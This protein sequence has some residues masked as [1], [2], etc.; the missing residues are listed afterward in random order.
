M[1]DPFAVQGV[2]KS[3][4]LTPSPSKFSSN[5]SSK[6][7]ADDDDKEEMLLRVITC[8]KSSLSHYYLKLQLRD[9][10]RTILRQEATIDG[11]ET[12]YHA[13]NT[14]AGIAKFIDLKT[15]SDPVNGY[16]LD[17][18]CVFGVEVFVVENTYKEGC[19]SM[20]HKPATCYHTWKV[21]NF[22]TLVN[23]KYVSESF[24]CYKWNILFFPNGNL[25]GKGNSFSL[26]IGLSL[27][28]IA[29]GTKLLAKVIMRVKNQMNGK[30]IEHK[31]CNLYGP[32]NSSGLG[33]T[34]FIS[35]AKLKDPEQGFLVDDTL[36]IEAEVTLLGMVLAESRL[37]IYPTGNKRRNG[38]DHISI[39]LEPAET[40]S[41][42]AGWEV[43][44][45][46]N[47]FI[48]NH[49]Q[50][51]Y[52][53]I[54][55][56]WET[57]YHA[58]N[59]MSGIAKF[60]DLKTFSNPENGYLLDDT[61]VFG[62]EVFVVKNTFKEGCLS[63]MHEPATCYHTWK[64]TNFST[65]VNEKYDSESFGCNKWYIILYPNGNSDGK[66][67][68]ISLFLGLSLSS[69]APGTKLLVK[70]IMRV[71]NQMNGKHIVYQVS[72]MYPPRNSIALGWPR[73]MSLAK[74]KDPKLGF[75][76]ND[77]LIIEAEV[78]LLGMV[79]AKS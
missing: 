74:L 54:K 40:S 10:A 66:G 13:M 30:Y 5:S 27:S 70:Q 25:E 23:E 75:L 21:T 59:T 72:D 78:T 58:M 36:I 32:Q 38:K 15:F 19:L 77:S 73:F 3:S 68:S 9:S 2:T 64:V 35:L 51:K 22:S 16:L 24:G 50:N 28:S 79:L 43:N 7:P 12:R 44:V 17:D 8:S 1:L 60:I 29:P 42:P 18:I 56:G 69:I 14:I 61:C 76:V 65:L 49:L 39:Y 26:Y 48:F 33:R 31:A 55:D 20:I 52:F 45:I 34:R 47:F 63:M 4:N 41:L 6:P 57:R 71:K 46:S 62:V 67:N 11:W 37:W 53:S